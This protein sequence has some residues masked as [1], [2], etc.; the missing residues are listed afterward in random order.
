VSG[1]VRRYE[2]ALVLHPDCGRHDTGWG[3]PEH[4]GRLPAIV[5]ALQRDTPD[6]LGRILQVEAEHATLEAVRRVHAEELIERVRAAAERAAAEDVLVR[7]EADTIVSAASWDA[8]LAAA[9]SAVSAADLVARGEAAT[10]FALCRP[11]GHHATPHHA[12]GFC[13]FNNVAI[14]ARH[15]QATHGAERVLIVDWDVHHGNGTQDVFYTDPSVYF[16]SLHLANHYPGTGDEAERGAGAGA[17]FTR[18]VPLVHGT[19]ADEYRAIFER[20]VDDVL[21]RF[22]PDFVLVS[23]G[24][25]CLAGDPLG[26]LLLEPADLHALTRALVQRAESACGGR[27]AVVLEGGYVP[28][29][30]GEGARAVLRALGGLPYA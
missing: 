10:A 12:M 5:Q 4:Q 22:A 1:G 6:F 9:G 27:V 29:R 24:F 16:V 13:L 17:G 20:V 7:V 30:V 3:H 14:A 11:P 23:A 21:A 25:D 2:T 18:N 19:S 15:V 26:G 28:A 8:A